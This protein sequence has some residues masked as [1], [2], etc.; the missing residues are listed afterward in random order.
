LLTML[1]LDLTIDDYAHRVSADKTD[2][3]S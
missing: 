1:P 3:P 2:G